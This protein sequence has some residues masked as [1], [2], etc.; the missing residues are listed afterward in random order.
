MYWKISRVLLAATLPTAAWD[1]EKLNQ[2][3]GWLNRS[4]SMSS[5]AWKKPI[6]GNI[7]ATAAAG[8][9]ALAAFPEFYISDSEWSGRKRHLAQH[10]A[11]TG[12]IGAKMNWYKLED[13]LPPCS[14]R[15]ASERA[16]FNR[17]EPRVT[18]CRVGKTTS[19]SPI[20]DSQS[21]NV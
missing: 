9:L 5:R 15:R 13:K 21:L 2:V 10:P 8:W 14:S 16:R 7:S 17:I 11:E 4:E 1:L 20:K 6:D 19:R 18:E 12:G 3:Y